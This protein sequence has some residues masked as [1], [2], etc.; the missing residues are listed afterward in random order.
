MENKVSIVIPVY[1]AENTLQGCL[2]SILNLQYKGLEAIFVDDGSKDKSRKIILNYTER[3]P[4]KIKLLFQRHKGP[5]AARNKGWRNS[6]GGI[7]FFTDSDVIVSQDWIIKT[8]PYFEDKKVAAVGGGIEAFSLE[9]LSEKFEQYRRNKLYGNKK[10]FTD[11]LPACNLAVRRKV[12]EEING[13]DE[14]FRF[15]SSEDY[16]LCYRIRDRGYK[17][18]Y[19]PTIKVLH[20]HSQTWKGVFKRGFIHG[21]EGIKLREKRGIPVIREI[22]KLGGVILLP[23]VVFIRYPLVLIPFGFTYDFFTYL[24]RVYGIL[25]YRIK[26]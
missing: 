26:K 10:R 21:K 11:T 22:I 13:F 18:F 16:D 14:S 1:N 2:N 12:L 9:G 6:K 17:I 5:S 8:L 19:D 23:L 20:C 25:K 24:G 3:H 15:A 4:K 7:I